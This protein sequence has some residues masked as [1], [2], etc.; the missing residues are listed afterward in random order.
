VVPTATA[1]SVAAA[2]T[3]AAAKAAAVAAAAAGS[4][5]SSSSGFPAVLPRAEQCVPR[6]FWGLMNEEL[7]PWHKPASCYSH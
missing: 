1:P 7:R 2:A 6:Q 5:S 4:A 3:R